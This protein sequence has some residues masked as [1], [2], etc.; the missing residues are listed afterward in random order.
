MK[1]RMFKHRAVPMTPE[2][3]EE[4]RKEM[5]TQS[6]D[7]PIGH[8]SAAAL[9]QTKCP[10]CGNKHGNVEQQFDSSCG[11]YTDFKM[12]CWACQYAWWVE[13]ADS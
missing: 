6:S 9:C 13:G 3:E 11:G 8:L 5:A 12:T 1:I 7:E 4:Y 10:K 2:N